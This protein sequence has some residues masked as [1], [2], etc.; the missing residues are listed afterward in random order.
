MLCFITSIKVKSI[1]ESVSIWLS[2]KGSVV[3]FT[4]IL[5]ILSSIKSWSSLA[6]S[7]FKT[8]FTLLVSENKLEFKSN[9]NEDVPISTL[10][11]INRSYIFKW[12]VLF[13]LKYTITFINKIIIIKVHKSFTPH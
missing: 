8:I 1:I 10:I 11:Y 9:F 4:F 6:T 2:I 3:S 7:F 13:A 12:K 5:D